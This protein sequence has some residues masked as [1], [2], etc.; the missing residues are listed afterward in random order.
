M[1]ELLEA[2]G[3]F[4]RYMTDDERREKLADYLIANGVV[5]IDPEKY[6]PVTNRGIIDKVMGMP[7][8]EVADLIRAKEE[9]RIIV[10]PCK[11]GTH[12]WK[13]TYPYRQEPKV[14][15][16]VVKN[17]M[18]VGK[19]HKIQIEVQ[20]VNVPMTNWMYYKDFYTTKAEAEKALAERRE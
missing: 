15:E 10:P 1:I 4:S 5:I 17:I 9:G 2:E 19:R 6:P 3:G 7:F 16:F 14:T 18:T 20:A 8:D 12:L 11:V 13:I